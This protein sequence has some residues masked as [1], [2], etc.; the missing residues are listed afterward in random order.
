MSIQEFSL[1]FITVLIG[2]GGQFCLKLGAQK[3]G[4]VTTENAI[5]HVL[6]IITTPELLLGLTFYGLSAVF[7]I[8]LLTR[9]PLS[10]IGPSVSL[11]YICS[12]LLGHYI[13]HEPITMRHLVGLAFIA[14]GVILVAWKK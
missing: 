12:V 5:S 10:V 14:C 1:F 2:V 7:Y 8:L 13:F 6:A 3:L 9:I 11:G 4:Q